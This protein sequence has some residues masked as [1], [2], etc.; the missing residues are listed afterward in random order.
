MRGNHSEAVIFRLVM[1]VFIL[2]SLFSAYALADETSGQKEFHSP[3]EAVA[4]FAGALK[5]DDEKELQ[6]IFGP[7]A[8]E[9]V[10]SGDGVNDQQRR[11]RFMENFSKAH[12][13]SEEGGK[14]ILLVGEQQWPFPI[15]L[16]KRGDLWSFDTAAGR[17]EIID[18][19]VGENELFTIQA[20]LAI[21]DAQREYALQDHDAD[22][23]SKYAR[24]F[25]SDPGKKNGLYWDAK[26]G[27]EQSPLGELVAKARG[28]GYASNKEKEEPTPYHGY[29]YRMLMAQGKNASGGAYDYMVNGKMIGGF[30]VV[31]YP[32]EYGNSGVMTFIVNHDGIVYQKDLGDETETMAKA[33]QLYDPDS[34]WKKAQ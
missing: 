1:A 24:K 12:S 26:E 34:S 18:R 19:R 21:V 22:G 27:E 30:A 17:E 25:A 5:A 23:L 9:L 7:E 20:M 8:E 33:M 29:Y 14:M 32:A 13:L 6:A 4:A 16:V 2:V 10:S 11:E 28:E 31:A 3:E 15:P